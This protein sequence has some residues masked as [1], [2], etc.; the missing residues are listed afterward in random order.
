MR[1]S[2]ADTPPRA[3]VEL[4]AL[5][6]LRFFAA[7]HVVLFH[8]HA[9]IGDSQ[10]FGLIAIAS[11]GHHAVA[12][13]FVLSGFILHHTYRQTDWSLPGERRNYLIHR[14]ARIY[15]VYALSFCVDA[16]RAVDFFLSHNPFGAGLFKAAFTG[17]AYLTLSQT[18]VPR[19][20]SAWNAPGWSLST[21]AFFYLLLPRLLPRIARLSTT[22]AVGGLAITLAATSLGQSL[23]RIA[24]ESAGLSETIWSPWMGVFP[25][26]RLSEF[27]F[28]VLLGHVFAAT[29]KSRAI[30]RPAV[31]L[32]S[33]FA[34]ASILL[35]SNRFTLPFVGRHHGLLLPFYGILIL[36]LTVVTNPVAQCLALRPLRFL[37]GAS[38]A[39]YLLHM[40]LFAYFH[41]FM[42]ATSWQASPGMFLVYLGGVLVVASLV[43]QFYEEPL[44]RVIRRRFAGPP[45][46]G[47]TPPNSQ[48]PPPDTSRFP[49]G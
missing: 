38:Y 49:P 47:A 17:T 6:G 28:G 44:R 20:A 39:I 37:G 42:A 40:P 12:L 33:L 32:L 14:V 10:P 35:L 27:I 48:V 25:P 16:P 18:W 31:T 24:I 7:L 34:I 45:D 3:R 26:L 2:T 29:E 11:G 5:T 1:R 43:F 46:V 13:F 41:R 19:L 15:P 9:L 30:S 36:G 22:Q 23:P 21:E 8:T 4:H